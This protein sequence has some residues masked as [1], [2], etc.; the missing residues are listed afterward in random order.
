MYKPYKPVAS[1]AEVLAYDPE[2]PETFT[3]SPVV[4]AVT[5]VLCATK[6]FECKEIA[7][8][9]NLDERKLSN[10]L[11]I[12]L[13]MTLSQLVDQYRANEVQEFRAQHPEYTAEE[14]AKA[15]G[16]ASPSG[17]SRFLST[18]LGITPQGRKTLRSKDK[19]VR[20]MSE[21]R[22]ITRANMSPEETREAIM[23]VK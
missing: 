1:L 23:K 5:E 4:N 16:Y 18:K 21:L 9:L 3:Q 7:R 6:L 15:I 11:S 17:I 22:A 14:L 8:C 19:H 12:D 10:A 20:I 2:N 13:G